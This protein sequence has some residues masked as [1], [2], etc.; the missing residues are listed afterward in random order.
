[1]GVLTGGCYS[2]DPAERAL[3]NGDFDAGNGARNSAATSAAGSARDAGAS[4]A[5]G[6]TAT[7]DAGVGNPPADASGASQQPATY[8][9]DA[10]AA[11]ASP[12]A[13]DASGISDSGSAAAAADAYVYPT[14]SRNCSEPYAEPQRHHDTGY[15]DST[16]HG[17]E[18]LLAGGTCK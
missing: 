17:P 3:L 5:I 11:D 8:V 18:A 14:L 10:S 13:A 6:A 2:V 7:V 9:S 12:V 4:T 15:D 1:M 16:K